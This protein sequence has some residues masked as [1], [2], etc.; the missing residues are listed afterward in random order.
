M[1]HRKRALE[2]MAEI[3]DERKSEMDRTQ[4]PSDFLTCYLFEHLREQEEG[5]KPEE[6]EFDLETLKFQLYNMFLG[7]RTFS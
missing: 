4:E 5:V 2:L 6:Q 1:K 7:I 3:V